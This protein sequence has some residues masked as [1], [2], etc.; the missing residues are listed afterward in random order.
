M[1]TTWEGESGKANLL[2]LL[3][4]S[5][6]Y[7]CTVSSI[8][9]SRGLQET[10]CLAQAEVRMNACSEQSLSSLHLQSITVTLAIHFVTASL[11]LVV[12]QHS[13]SRV[14]RYTVGP[15]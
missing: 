4:Y 12:N 9:T 10:Y 7:G 2:Y 15:L 14:P 11:T 5:W 8:K 1:C 6:F 3:S 13:V